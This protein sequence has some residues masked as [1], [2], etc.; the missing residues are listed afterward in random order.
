[1]ITVNNI[2]FSYS[3]ESQVFKQFN[4]HVN[5]GALFGLLAPNGAG[6][7]TLIKLLTGINVPSSGEIQIDGKSYSTH[8]NLILNKIAIV[9]QEYA[10]YSQFTAYENL[11]FFSRL[12]KHTDSETKIQRALDISQLQDHQHRLAKHYSGG[13]KRRLNFAIGLLNDPD[14]LILD[15]PTV[16]IDAQSRQFI[17]QAIKDI[18]DRGTT[19]LFT[20]H[21]IDE[22]EKT[23]DT[24]AIM[25][26]GEIQ[27]AGKINQL[28]GEKIV[29]IE[30]GGKVNNNQ[31]EASLTKYARENDFIFE[32]HKISGNAADTKSI[33]DLILIVV[34]LGFNIDRIHYDQ[35]NL[36]SLFFEKIKSKMSA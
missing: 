10:F 22:I 19:I 16:G 1:M 6:K 26:E 3:A 32:H 4:L 36:E 18:N 12:Y 34:D 14:L 11:H 15:E 23:C 9:P 30:L 8:R 24:I 31:A 7:T 25:D 35:Q 21:Y 13:L 20:S 33:S 2:D 17:L 27:A 5:K 28:L 29:T